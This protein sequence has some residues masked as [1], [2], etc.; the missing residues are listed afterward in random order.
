MTY[1]PKGNNT[2][3]KN[4]HPATTEK[5]YIGKEYNIGTAKQIRHDKKKEINKYSRRFAPVEMKK[6]KEV[7]SETRK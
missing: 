2:D 6:K 5:N 4:R 7:K 3:G 1:T